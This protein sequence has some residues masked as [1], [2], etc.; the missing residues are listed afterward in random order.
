MV[1]DVLA[2]EFF[3]M[4]DD[5]F[6]VALLK[7]DSTM[8]YDMVVLPENLGPQLHQMN[9]HGIVVSPPLNEALFVPGRRVESSGGQTGG[10]TGGRRGFLADTEAVPNTTC[11][12]VAGDVAFFPFKVFL[13]IVRNCCRIVAPI[14]AFGMIFYGPICLGAPES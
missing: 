10:A 5:E 8:L 2:L 1:I 11:C 13:L 3:T 9:D 7:Y 14:I 4:L 12:D 6:K